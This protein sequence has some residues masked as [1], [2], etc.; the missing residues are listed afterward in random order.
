[1]T[2]IFA[3]DWFA[4]GVGLILVFQLL[5]ILLGE[6]I[7][8]ADRRTLPVGGIFRALRN[9]VLPFAVLFVFL[10]RLLEFDRDSVTV[11]LVEMALWVSVVYAVLLVFNVLVFENVVKESWRSCALKLF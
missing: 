7:Y 11:R 6:A 5:V 4:W 8:R 1:M 10:T 9:I 3:S 2:E